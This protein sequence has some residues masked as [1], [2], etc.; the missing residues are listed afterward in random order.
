[1]FKDYLKQGF[2]DVWGM[3]WDIPGPEPVGKT[4]KLDPEQLNRYILMLFPA[5]GL[6]AG[7]FTLAVA[8][9]CSRLPGITAASIVFAIV[10]VI[11][12]EILTGGR[13]LSSVAGLIETVSRR[14]GF[15]SGLVTMNDDIHAARGTIG[16]LVLIAILALRAVCF[17]IL[18]SSMFWS[19]LPVT[20]ILAYAMQAHLATLP[21]LSSGRE[22]IRTDDNQVWAMWI[23]AGLAGIII[24]KGHFSCVLAAVL[25]VCFITAL[26]KKYFQL[27]TDGI[28][29]NIIGAMSYTAETLLLLFGV[30]FAAV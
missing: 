25:L 3:L 24:G 14:R 9:L 17:S 28:T 26:L 6:M 10:A 18:F 21:S 20:F 22:I 27:R 5:F 2:S 8:W 13:N 29:G 12:H 1:M 30:A 23:V 7:I 19:W 4:K 16:M 11:C 15:L